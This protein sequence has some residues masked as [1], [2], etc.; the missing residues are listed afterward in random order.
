MAPM[1]LDEPAT[2]LLTKLY[3]DNYNHA[4]TEWGGLSNTCVT[5]WA[6]LPLFTNRRGVLVRSNH[7]I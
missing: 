1:F 4:L 7:I 2:E 3:L 5:H 6:R